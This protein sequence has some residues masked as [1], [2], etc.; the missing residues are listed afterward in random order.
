MKKFIKLLLLVSSLL[1]VAC[2]D[3][4]NNNGKNTEKDHVWKET[5]DTI[6]KAK[7]V[8]GMIMESAEETRKTLE[9]QGE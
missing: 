3:D 9:Q 4:S 2:S 6:D 8:E 1:L 5:T 7:Q